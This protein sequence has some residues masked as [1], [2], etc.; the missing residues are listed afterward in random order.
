MPHAANSTWAKNC[1]G[2]KYNPAP[3][4]A[5]A[6]SVTTTKQLHLSGTSHGVGQALGPLFW[7]ANTFSA[8]FW[9]TNAKKRSRCTASIVYSSS[10]MLSSQ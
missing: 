9:D 4:R 8:E 2:Y 6:G 5:T 10:T 7:S 1:P 3:E